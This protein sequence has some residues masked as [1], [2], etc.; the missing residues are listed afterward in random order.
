MFHRHFPKAA[1]LCC[2]KMTV[3]NLSNSDFARNDE[4]PQTATT[5]T[6]TGTN[7]HT[8]PIETAT[9]H[10]RHVEAVQIEVKNTKKIKQFKF[11]KEYNIFLQDGPIQIRVPSASD[12]NAIR[13]NILKPQM[14]MAWQQRKKPMPI[15]I[16][17]PQQAQQQ[18]PSIE[19]RRKNADS[20][21]IK[22]QKL[23]IKINKIIY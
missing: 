18:E 5:P 12:D 6:T 4:P 9:N 14:P 13:E 7:R 23:F 1:I 10:P 17:R 22:V 20:G 3:D 2:V 16:V 19:P 8:S 21:S 15:A 11:Y